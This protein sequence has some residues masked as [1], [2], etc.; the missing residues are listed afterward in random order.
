MT[1]LF[2]VCLDINQEDFDQEL[3]EDANYAS[4]LY[5]KGDDY[6]RI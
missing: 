4:G 2:Y 6:R 3:L 1:K 5:R